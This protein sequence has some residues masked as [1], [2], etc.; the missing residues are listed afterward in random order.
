MRAFAVYSASKVEAE[1][2]LW[3]F[4]KEEKPGFVINTVLPDTA[5]GKILDRSLPA[6]TAGFITKLYKGEQQHLPPRKSQ[7]YF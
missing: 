1:K 3:K 7:T 4:V 2:A 6:S 5:Y